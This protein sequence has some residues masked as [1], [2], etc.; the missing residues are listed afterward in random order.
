[1]EWQKL[2]MQDFVL[3]EAD[4]PVPKCLDLLNALGPSHVVVHRR[5]NDGGEYYYLFIAQHVLARL[6]GHALPDVTALAALDLHESGSVAPR[7]SASPVELWTQRCVIVREGTVVGYFDAAALQAPDTRRRGGEPTPAPEA[8]DRS[9]RA[10]FP[11]TVPLNETTSLVVYLTAAIAGPGGLAVRA[12]VG[13]Q[14]DI[15]VQ[16]RRGFAIDGR[17]EG[18]LLMTDEPESL[19][20]QFKLRATEVGPGQIRVLAFQN[21]IA[22]GALTLTPTVTPAVPGQRVIAW[23]AMAPVSV[24]LPDLSLLIE[25][26]RV[27]GSRGFTLRITAVDA[28]LNL[29]FRKFGPI[30]F[31]TD[32]G[33]YFEALYK[34]IEG[35]PMQTETQKVIAVRQ[36]A[37]KGTS[38]FEMLVPAEARKK[39]WELRDRITSVLVQSE[40]P[41]IPW[42]LCKL[43]GEEN[44]AIVEGPFLCEAFAITRWLLGTGLKPALTLKNLAVVVP[45]DSGL[46]YAPQER[47]YLLSLAGNDRQVTRVNARFLDVVTALTSGKYDAWHFSGHGVYR[48]PDPNRS[49]MFLESGETF[50]PTNI[51]GVV[52]NLGKA[53]PVVFLNACQ[54]GRSGESLTGLG[55]WAR[56]FVE[57]GAGAFIGAYWSVYDYSA[58]SFAKELYQRLLARVP[59]GKAALEARLAVKRHDDPTWLAYTVFADPFATLKS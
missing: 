29:N 16:A 15:L 44:G 13:T 45:S 50:T 6:E 43:S 1:M 54:I 38:L 27:N 48:D 39:L 58:Y 30:A 20:V 21:G 18:T 37:A 36:L 23:E 25:E 2:A 33:P 46:P 40:E 53:R 41:W 19:P 51:A 12:A 24:R 42:E 56:Q 59:I 22:L 26:T 14:V 11:E 35:Y 8:V 9:L 32:P 49:K 34:D 5:D 28:S 7:D 57:A 47:D 55:G 10:E 3:L 4:W 52:R 17:A 31:Q